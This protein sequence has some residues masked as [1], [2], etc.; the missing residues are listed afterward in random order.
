MDFSFLEYFIERQDVESQSSQTH[1][2]TL[3]QN[4]PLSIG[5]LSL[6]LLFLLHQLLGLFY[7]VL[8][9]CHYLVHH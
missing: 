7:L 1:V 2:K 4:W 6:H 3:E 5:R 8:N 9:P